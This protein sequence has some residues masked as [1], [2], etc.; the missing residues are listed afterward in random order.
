MNGTFRDISYPPT[1]KYSSDSEFIPLEFYEETFPISK[2]IDLLLGYFSSNAIKVLSKSFAEFIYNGGEMRLITNHVY[3]LVDYENLLNNTE[4]KNED[5]IIDIFTDLAETEKNLS[6]EGL[7]FFDCL[8]YLLNKKKLEIT[9]VKFNSI[10][11]A[12]CKKMI[13]YDGNDYIIT[14]GSINFTLPALIKNSE[15]FQVETPWNGDVS[16]KRIEDE[17]SNFERIVNKTHP[18]Y[19]YIEITD[20]EIVINSIGRD[21]EISDLLDD[22]LELKTKGY[23]E[24]VK[25]IIDRKKERFEKKI[26]LISNTPKFPFSQGPREYQNSAYQNW[27]NNNYC[28]IFAMA[29]GTGKTITA[30]NCLLKEYEINKT[31][32]SI[33]LVPTTI[34]LDQWH[35]EV[36]QFNFKSV[37]TSKDRF[38]DKNLSRL[39]FLSTNN[40]GQNFVFI[41]TYATYNGRKFQNL[42]N[43]KTLNDIVII[44]DEAHNLGAP[45]AIKNLPHNIVKRIGLSATPN[46]KYDF[47][48]TIKVEQYFKSNSP[49]YTFTFSMN[50]AIELGYLSRYKYFPYLTSLTYEELIL[51]KDLSK[52]LL[53]HYDFNKGKYKESAEKLLIKRKRIIHQANNKKNV[54]REI[55]ND[56]SGKEKNHLTHTLV[57]VPEGY[58]HNYNDIDNYEVKIEDQRI[59]N[60]YSKIISD[61]G[62]STYQILS[63]TPNRKEIL[64]SFEEGKIAVLT[65]MK[66]L[67][68]GVDVPATKYAIFCSST[69]NPRQFIQRRGRVL[70]TFKGKEMAYVY[71]IIV[72]PNPEIWEGESI[73]MKGDLEKMEEN[74]FRNE[75]F[76]VANFLYA[77]ENRYDLS[78]GKD[79]NLK[80]IVDISE[81]YK[82]NLNGLIT[83]LIT[84]DKNIN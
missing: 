15:S 45:K 72:A 64:K 8:K 11:L 43:N 53:R 58:E 38:W 13:L 23:S 60:E 32:Q 7:H 63:E 62:L 27:V 54:F 50:R 66:T 16:I 71:D 31:Y 51:Y 55:I 6:D 84:L 49:K 37:F 41:T 44:A 42:V 26:E 68:E 52:K 36:K 47:E 46:R 39:L 30:L 80:K 2:R 79:K 28:G 67:D 3:S 65:S 12:H 24:K 19:E 59:I 70:R 83:E 25:K 73:K 20:I 48:G 34:L 81:K 22:S 21:K 69:G 4:L 10:D 18:N 56:I 9:P 74:I 35:N 76:R 78:V 61:L 33:I 57:Y 75:L 82:I 1:Y 29:T 77:C 17:K 5:K 14:E 40:N